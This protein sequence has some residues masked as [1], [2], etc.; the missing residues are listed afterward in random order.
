MNF[1]KIPFV[2]ILIPF[3]LGILFYSFYNCNHDVSYQMVAVFCFLLILFYSSNRKTNFYKNASFI[4]ISDVFLLI[5]GFYSCYLFNPKTQSNYY[6]Y[7]V[8][9][10]TQN[11][12]GEVED[13]PIEKDNFYKAIVNVKQIENNLSNGKLLVYFKKPVDANRLK[14]GTNVFASSKLIEISSPQNPDEFDYKSYMANKG[15]LYQTFV[16]QSQI[17]K[18][19]LSPHSSLVQFAIKIKLKILNSLQKS[20]LSKNSVALSSALITGYDDMISADVTNAF[21]H[22][23]TLHVLSVSGLHTGILFTLVVF[24]LGLIDPYDRYKKVKLIVVLIV[25]W[26][27]VF[28]AGFSAPV[29]RAA[30]MLSFVSV[31]K[32]YFNYLSN[33]AIN[34]LAFS[35]FL[36]LLFNP[37]LIYDVGFLL[38][39]TAVLGILLFEPS[40]TNLVQT[41]YSFVN[42]I[43]QLSSVSIAAQ[44]STLPITLCFFHQFP[45]WFLFSNLLIIP[46]CMILMFLGL[47]AVLGITV[48]S[49]LINS[50]TD[51]VINL[52]NVTN[53]PGIGYIDKIDFNYLDV[54]FLSA[55]IITSAMLIRFRKFSHMINTLLLIIG[56]ITCS[57]I[58]AYTNKIKSGVIIYQCNK[59]TAIDIKNKTELIK[60]YNVSE[61]SYDFHIKNHHSYF[62]YPNHIPL[63]VNYIVA[64]SNKILIVKRKADLNLCQHLLP[65]YLILTNNVIPN[66]VHLKQPKLKQVIC[67]GSNTYKSIKAIKKLCTDLRISFYPTKEYGYLELPL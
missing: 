65:N 66:I 27:F 45:I 18:D 42:K 41:K 6:G 49:S 43:W 23:G 33:A 2:R 21:A 53:V 39:Y 4:L 30:I 60:D 26:S 29:L 35:A 14:N 58:D 9:S 37:L 64:N 36:I 47:L 20:G 3:V 48:I 62:N 5:T 55:L 59:E 46:L 61:K 22:S 17:L 44:I 56:W 12:I 19:T 24:V 38:S 28:V 50:L 16:E 15:V 34:I 31:G 32:Y 11:W 10:E 67:D 52:V 25:L 63:H 57:T 13:I 7:S 51:L 8:N 54:M 1:S 40:I